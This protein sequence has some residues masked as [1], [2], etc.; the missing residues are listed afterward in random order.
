MTALNFKY[1]FIETGSAN[2]FKN[3]YGFLVDVSVYK[4]PVS[5]HKNTRHMIK[6]ILDKKEYMG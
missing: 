3:Q 4:K 5:G 1:G 6:D 2:I